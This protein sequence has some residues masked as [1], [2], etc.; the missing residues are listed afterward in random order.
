ME[1]TLASSCCQL[2]TFSGLSDSLSVCVLAAVVSFALGPVSFLD[3][4]VPISSLKSLKS[5]IGTRQEEVE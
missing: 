5:Q 1:D 3:P 2:E 4:S